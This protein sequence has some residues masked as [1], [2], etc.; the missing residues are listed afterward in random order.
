MG[1]LIFSFKKQGGHGSVRAGNIADIP[2]AD[3]PEG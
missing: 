1:K 3:D 2:A